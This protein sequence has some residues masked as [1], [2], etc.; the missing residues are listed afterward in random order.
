VKILTLPAGLDPDDLIRQNAEQ[1][2]GLVSAATPVVD[3]VLNRLAERHDLGAAAGKR[4][5]I[6][7][8]AMLVFRDLADPV[9]R[10]HYLQ[11]L[12]AIV[13]LDEGGTRAA[14]RTALGRLRPRSPGSAEPREPAPAALP[15]AYALALHFVLGPESPGLGSDAVE[16]AEGRAV[17]S[18]ITAVAADERNEAGLARLVDQAGPGLAAAL[19]QVA[20]WLPRIASLP[21]E[22]RKRELEVAGLKLRQRQLMTRYREVQ[23][24]LGEPDSAQ[25]TP[26]A[27]S[28]L[29]SIAQQ[30]HLID[31]ALL[32]QHGVGS[33]VWRSRQAGEVLGG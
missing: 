20:G 33:L 16:T 9:E 1:W 4:E 24:L 25:E 13:G 23:S 18:L 7:E 21:V 11:R 12:A 17:L 15:E 30:L 5:A 14:L 6:E 26:S 31:S 19:G 22:E 8:A 27:A 10:E 32:A 2:A 29:A 3:F 28:L